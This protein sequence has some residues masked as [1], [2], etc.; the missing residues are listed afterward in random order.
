[1]QLQKKRVREAVSIVVDENNVSIS[2]IEQNNK[3]TRPRLK[4]HK[5]FFLQSSEIVDGNIYNPTALKNLIQEFLKR[6]NLE[7]PHVAL[8][9]NAKSLTEKFALMPT[10]EPTA[11]FRHLF[12][13]KEWHYRYVCHA[14]NDDRFII[15]ACGLPREYIFH[16]QLFALYADLNLQSLTSTAMTRFILYKKMYGAAFRQ[17][18]LSAHLE[19]HNFDLATF[20]TPDTI[21]RTLIIPRDIEVVLDQEH[22][23]LACAVGLFL[24]ETEFHGKY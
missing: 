1:M 10:P 11:D 7:H 22:K 13:N 8:A 19:Q 6:H 12:K 3:N 18:Q 16:Y 20:F 9:L 23:A 4:A 17:S 5:T 24:S 21:A 14:L 15:Y 2:W